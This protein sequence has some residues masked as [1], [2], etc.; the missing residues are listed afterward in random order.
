MAVSRWCFAVKP[1]RASPLT[2]CVK[3]FVRVLCRYP[4]VSGRLGDSSPTQMTTCLFTGTFC[5]DPGAHWLACGAQT[6]AQLLTGSS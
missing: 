5:Y 4:A 3:L 6:G 2:S 1:A